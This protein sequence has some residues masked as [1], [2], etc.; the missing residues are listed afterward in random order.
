MRG[1]G[2][3]NC[4]KSFRLLVPPIVD[5]LHHQVCI[6]HR[7]AVLEKVARLQFQP[8]GGHRRGV[9]DHVRQVEQYT[10]RIRSGRQHGLEQMA[11]P[12]GNIGDGMEIGKIVRRQDTGGLTMCLTRHGA[13]EETAVFRVIGEVAPEASVRQRLLGGGTARAKRVIEVG[14]DIP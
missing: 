4:F 8:I 6:A 14:A 1:R 7:K 13:V 12:A 3:P 9:L 11:V 10:F 5:D 2:A